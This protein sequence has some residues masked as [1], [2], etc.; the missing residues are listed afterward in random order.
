MNRPLRDDL[1]LLFE[2]EIGTPPPGARQRVLA[3]VSQAVRRP[4][5]R[6]QAAAGLV[7][8]LLAAAIVATLLVA[9][10]NQ[11]S[12]PGHK[13]TGVIPWLPLPAQ[14]EAP[15]VPTP[16]PSPLPAGTQPCAPAQLLETITRL[17][18]TSEARAVRV[19][20]SPISVWPVAAR[21]PALCREHPQW[22]SS[23]APVSRCHS[24]CDRPT[25]DRTRLCQS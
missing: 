6:W 11:R 8:V 24:R 14:L 4:A 19:I 3:G 12:V 5:K 25:W 23:T 15:V 1:R 10:E 2:R 20:G 13:P 16:T 9:R 18:P 22:R 21:L 17:G 7:A